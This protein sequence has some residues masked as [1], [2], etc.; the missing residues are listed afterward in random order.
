VIANFPKHTLI[1]CQLR[2]GKPARGPGA[3]SSEDDSGGIAGGM[4]PDGTPKY[5]CTCKSP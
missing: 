4:G 3:K 1:P 2:S 5:I